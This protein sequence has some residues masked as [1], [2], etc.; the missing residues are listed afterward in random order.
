MT[1]VVEDGLECGCVIRYTITLGTLT[2]YGDKLVYSVV[3]VP[4]ALSM[5][6]RA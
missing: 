3:D 4:V 6:L 1:H 5:L 2:L